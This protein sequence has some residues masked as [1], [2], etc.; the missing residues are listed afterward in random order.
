MKNLSALDRRAFLRLTALTAGGLAVTP[1]LFAAAGLTAVSSSRLDR[2]ATGANVC[3]WF[4]FPQSNSAGHFN[5][6]ISEAERN[7]WLATG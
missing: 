5:N 1:S 6:Y 4:R 2:L 3:R 7:T